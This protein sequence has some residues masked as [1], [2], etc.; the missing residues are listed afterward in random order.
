MSTPFKKQ[1]IFLEVYGLGRMIW[2]VSQIVGLTGAY[3]FTE[4]ILKYPPEAAFNVMDR[5]MV[6]ITYLAVFLRGIFH[7]HTAAE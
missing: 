7:T 4:F 5:D 2:G 1:R 3:F 6:T